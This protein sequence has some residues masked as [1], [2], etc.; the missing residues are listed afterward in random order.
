[1]LS[2]GDGNHG[3]QTAAYNLPNDERVIQRKGSKKVML[4][5]VQHAK[6]DSTLLPISRLVLPAAAQAD[7]SFDWFFTHILAHELSHGIG[8]HEIQVGGRKSSVRLELKEIYSTLEEAKADI[9]GLFMLQYFFDHGILPGGEPNERKLYN[10]FLA[11]SFRTLRFGVQEAHGRGMALQFNYLTD[12]GAFLSRPDGTFEVN[13][14]NVKIAVRDL[15]RDLLT[16]EAQGDYPA[17]QR[18]LSQLGVMRPELTQALHRL[19]DIPVDIE[20]VFVT[21]NELAPSRR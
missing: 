17:G 21:A 11:S 5:N 10:T 14:K 18:M 7:L 1:V 13:F 2:A 4:K 16:I 12:H 8:P 6:F 15:T 9:T 3:V 19:G 20:P